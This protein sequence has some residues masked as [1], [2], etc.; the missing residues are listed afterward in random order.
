MTKDGIGAPLLRKEDRRLLTG[1]GRFSGDVTATGELCAVFRRSDVAHGVIKSIDATE[2]RA[3]PGIV[4]VFTAADLFDGMH[5]TIGTKFELADG[6]GNPIPN[7]PRP[8]LSHDKVRMA[9]DLLALVLAETDAQARDAAEAIEVDIEVLTASGTIAA[10]TADNTS[11]IWDACPDNIAF[12]WHGGDG[13]AVEAA[14][15][16]AAHKVTLDLI[17]NKITANPME[18]RCALAVPEADGKLRLVMGNQAPHLLRTL[19]AGLLSMP[20]QNITVVSEDMGGGFGMRTSPYG[21]EVALCRAAI[22]VDRP[23]RW[24]ATR[25][26]VVVGD[27]AARAQETRACLALD[28]NGRMLGLKVHTRADIGCYTTGYGPGVAVMLYS[29]LIPN[30]YR[31]PCLF[32]EIDSV[33]TNTSPTAPYRG[34]GRPEAVYLMERLMDEAAAQLGIDPLELRK[35][36]LIARDALPYTTA[37]GLTYD[38]GDFLGIT[39]DALALAD[40]PGFDGRAKQSTERNRRRGFGF[41]SFVETSAMAAPGVFEVAHVRFHPGGSAVVAVGTHSHGQGHATAFAQIAGERLGMP[42]DLVE[43]VYG[44][45]SKAP[46]GQGTYAS[47]STALAGPAILMAADKVIEK[48]RRIAAHMLE[49]SHEDIEFSQGQFTVA[50]TDRAM[51]WKQVAAAAY[52]PVNFADANLEPGLE[53]QAFYVPSGG[54]FPNGCHVAEVEVDPETGN[55]TLERYIAV[56]DVGTVINPLLLEGQIHGGI[57]QGV[58]Q[59]KM[60]HAVFDPETA[61][62]LAGTFLDYAM[63][64]ADD[65]PSF[66]RAD[67]PDPCLNNR[68]GVKGAGELGTIGAPPVIMHALLNA[69]RPLGVTKLDMPATSHA[70]WRAI[71]DAGQSA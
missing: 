24:T 48:G 55:W 11:P 71:H 38:S 53:E 2:A 10:A 57:A 29:P 61:Q 25:N 12:R 59:A 14:M 35:R 5:Q 43:I 60:E 49:A 23:L 58:G 51:T 26:E 3:M 9:G 70:V 40:Q 52:V 67:R 21:E 39:N 45:T 56:D 66:E 64:R 41:A 7:L 65:L 28:A 27:L 50:G 46:Y 62:P 6:D 18:P 8:V 32:T 44:D 42:A 34:A 15:K 17:N 47:R 4:A 13:I 16:T 1:K 36:N 22:K 69:L 63:P 37:T 54:T 19:L 20:E 31:L 33:L 68:L 30:V